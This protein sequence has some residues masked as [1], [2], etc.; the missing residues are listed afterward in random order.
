MTE[1]KSVGIYRTARQLAPLSVLGYGTH[2]ITTWLPDRRL[3]S[4]AAVLVQEGGGRLVSAR[5]GQLEVV[6]PALFWLFPGEVHAYGPAPGTAWQERWVLFGGSLCSYFIDSGLIDPARPLLALTEFT[7]VANLFGA[8]HSSILDETPLG[9]AA[10]GVALHR[11][12]VEAVRQ[13]RPATVPADGPDAD[14]LA[15]NLRARAFE[16]IDFAAFAEAFGM[17]PATLRRRFVSRFGVGPKAMQLDIRLDRAKALLAASDETIE[18]VAERVGFADSYYFS[19]VF[20]SREGR[21]P[22]EFRLRNRRR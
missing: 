2:T 4:Y 17:S 12:A 18:Q 16:P 3:D 7:P 22:S 21:S 6:G 9:R 11:L 20:R 1:L 15:A 13:Q 10:G 14:E 5:A 19:R 8:I